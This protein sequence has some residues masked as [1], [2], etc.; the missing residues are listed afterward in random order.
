MMKKYT[1]NEYKEMYKRYCEA[2]KGASLE[3]ALNEIFSRVREDENDSFDKFKTEFLSAVGINEYDYYT[4]N[5]NPL[6]KNYVE[7]RIFPEYEKNDKGHG[8]LH[9]LEV[10]RRSFALRENLGL[11]LNDD[12]MYVI[13]A[14]H[15]W[16]KHQEHEKGIKH[17][18]IAGRK[19]MEDETFTKFFSEDERVLIKEAIEDHSSSL[20]EE[21]RTDYGKLV[22][23]ADRNTSIKMV[24]IRSFFVGKRKTPELRIDDY[25]DY[26][27]KRLTKRYSVE[28]S[29]NMF[30]ADETY[31]KFLEDMR[32][33]LKDEKRFKDHYC[34][35]NH[36][37]SYD[38][39]LDEEPG[40]TGYINLFKREEKVGET[41]DK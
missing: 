22:S 37:T 1:S 39:I 15:D 11:D 29:E 19:F 23:S 26:T 12:Y 28:D 2:Y 3:S 9:I 32:N 24:F 13:A 6:L 27:F 21:P 41:Y 16:G 25:L 8:I 5:V 40:E 30:F 18:I 38:H 10:I 4:K 31:T 7:S 34:E 33:L 17:A 36:I 14:C 20:E 35:V